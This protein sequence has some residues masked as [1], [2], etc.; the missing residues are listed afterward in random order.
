MGFDGSGFHHPALNQPVIN[1]GTGIS[2]RVA[3]PDHRSTASAYNVKSGGAWSQ[4]PE[5]A[6]YAAF[7]R[8]IV[9]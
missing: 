1:P 2:W 7:I 8:K 4:I 9:S 6:V 3:F 5:L